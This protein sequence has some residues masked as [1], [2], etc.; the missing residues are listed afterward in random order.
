MYTSL[1]EAASFAVYIIDYINNIVLWANRFVRSDCT[2]RAGN[3]VTGYI[4]SHCFNRTDVKW[5]ACV[6]ETM[7]AI[8]QRNVMAVR[9][10]EPTR[11]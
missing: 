8:M 4:L 11:R 2:K 3:A 1:L 7:P 10:S 6:C 9:D 5:T